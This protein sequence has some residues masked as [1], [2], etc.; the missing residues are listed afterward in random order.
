MLVNV[1]M[2]GNEYNKIVRNDCYNVQQWVD[3]TL[4]AIFDIG[5]NIGIFSV[6]MKMRH[7]N[8]KIIAVEPLQSA[9]KFIKRNIHAHG[10]YL[11]EKAFGN[12]QTF[13]FYNR[14]HILDSIYSPDEH[15]EAI[16]SIALGD[17]FSKHECSLDDRYLMKFNCEGGERYLIGDEIAEKILYHAREVTMQVHFKT[18]FTNFDSWLNFEDYDKW[19]KSTFTHHKIASNTRWNK[20][21]TTHYTISWTE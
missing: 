12:G 3:G 4:D 1:R 21:G 5:A 13:H 9:N 18:Q 16:E 8:A 2:K 14:G 17:L 6:M 19:I 10:I 15:G 11:E 20:R 7:P